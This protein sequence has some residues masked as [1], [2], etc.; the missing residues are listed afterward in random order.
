MQANPP[1]LFSLPGCSGKI[2]DHWA[3]PSETKPDPEDKRPADWDEN[4]EI[5][6]P[7]ETKPA[8]YVAS[9]TPKKKGDSKVKNCWWQSLN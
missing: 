3:F 4:A 6:D 2:A 5:P 7:S 8:E 1:S 9:F